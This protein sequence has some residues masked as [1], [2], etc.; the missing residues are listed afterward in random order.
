MPDVVFDT[1]CLAGGDDQEA[2][3]R[4]ARDPGE[5]RQTG[6]KQHQTGDGEGRAGGKTFQKH[7]ANV[8]EREALCYTSDPIRP[9]EC[10]PS[11]DVPVLTK[12][13]VFR[14]VGGPFSLTRELHRL[15]R[16]VR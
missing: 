10:L 8:S 1:M 9:N 4:T 16:R 11:Y 7:E 12:E 15:H 6:D 5:G 13:D 2:D 14:F 3:D